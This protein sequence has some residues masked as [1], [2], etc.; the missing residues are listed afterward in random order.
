MT[1]YTR[2][3]HPNL[4]GSSNSKSNSPREVDI[5][6][7]LRMFYHSDGDLF[8]LQSALRHL[9][10]ID[11]LQ[12]LNTGFPGDSEIPERGEGRRS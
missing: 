9:E 4:A 2:T 5:F 8:R 12:R 6:D 1:I 7:A 11:D 3:T 10:T